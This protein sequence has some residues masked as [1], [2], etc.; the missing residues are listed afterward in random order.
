[1]DTKW[2]NE[3][4]LAEHKDIDADVMSINHTGQYVALA[5]PR[6]LY[7]IDID[8]LSEISRSIP[9][10]SKWNVTASE[11][12]PHQAHL[13]SLSYNNFVTIYSLRGN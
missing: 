5:N 10:T 9:R 4:T 11:W 13:L 6:M 8:N 7:I 2:S 1:M 12:N 3:K